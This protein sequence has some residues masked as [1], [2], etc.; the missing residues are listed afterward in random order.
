MPEFDTIDLYLTVFN[1]YTYPHGEIY[2]CYWA[3]FPS[4]Y[5][6]EHGTSD[7]IRP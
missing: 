1:I 7:G 3:K 2:A 5:R 4:E 6:L